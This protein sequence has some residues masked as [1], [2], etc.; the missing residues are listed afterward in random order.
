MDIENMRNVCS[1]PEVDIASSQYRNV[2]YQISQK[3]I[4]YF[5]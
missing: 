5:L 1:D 2:C 4:V 3:F